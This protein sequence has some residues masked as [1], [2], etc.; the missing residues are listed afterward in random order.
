VR[1]R[2]RLS[3]VAGRPGPEDE[4]LLHPGQ[5]SQLL[6]HHQR[7]LLLYIP[8]GRRDRTSAVDAL[9]FHGLLAV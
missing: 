5:T 9:Y 1:R 3:V 4:R 7:R 8:E 2:N 6:R